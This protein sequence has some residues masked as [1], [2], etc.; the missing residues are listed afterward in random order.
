VTINLH[1]RPAS[2]RSNYRPVTVGGCTSCICQRMRKSSCY[3]VRSLPG[4]PPRS[5]PNHLFLNSKDYATLGTLVQMNP[6]L[7]QPED[8]AALWQ[9]LHDGV[10]DFVATDHAPHTLKEKRQPYPRSPSG[11]PG[12]ETSLPL[13]LTQLAAGKCTLAEI[14]K[15]M[16]HGPAQAYGIPNKGKILEG[17]DA[18]LVLVDL[19]SVRPVVN[20]NLY[21][22]V[23]WSPYSGWELK[24][25]PLYTIVGGQIAF[26]RGQFR[27]DVRGRALEFASEQA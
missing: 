13:M 11:M 16:C 17:W 12:V 5:S 8:N 21:T 26:E 14:Q 24:G 22:R 19:E 1:W 7:R 15:W 27:A 20:E 23:G 2:L 10:I 6:P 25:W 4:L 3:D 18:D 9:A